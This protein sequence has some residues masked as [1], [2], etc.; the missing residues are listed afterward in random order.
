[1]NRRGFLKMSA[2]TGM[3]AGLAVPGHPSSGGI[4]YAATGASVKEGAAAEDGFRM[5]AE[6]EPHERTL[7]QF[8]PGQNWSAREIGGARGEWAAVANAVSEFE[9][10]TMAADPRD[11]AIARKL[12][13]AEIEL[14]EMP[15]NDGWSR[16]SG[17]IILTNDA[18]QRRVA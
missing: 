8:V 5:P 16:D 10:V 3:S 2:A 13:S 14:V 17:P 9:P 18:G 1:M 12:L 11:M 6:W 4:D 15:L 7:M